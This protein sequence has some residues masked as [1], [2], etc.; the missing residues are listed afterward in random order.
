MSESVELPI[1][2]SSAGPSGPSRLV[3]ATDGSCLGNP[4]AGGWCWYVDA[5]RWASGGT[6][7]TTNNRMELAAVGALLV[8][9]PETVVLHIQVDSRYV[10]DALTKWR[11]GWRRRGWTTASGAPVRNQDL[12][13]A[14]DARLERHSIEWEW[15]RSHQGHP[16]NEAADVRARAAAERAAGGQPGK[17]GPG[18]PGT[19]LR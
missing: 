3:V 10:L 4:G 13:M 15:V 18:W 1:A 11:F 12:L 6:L 19:P 8:A 7:S 16:R 5:D 2:Q 9:V 17:A 14:L